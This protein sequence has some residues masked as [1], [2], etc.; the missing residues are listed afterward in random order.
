MTVGESPVATTQGN[1][2]WPVAVALVLF[3]L[4][5]YG[6]AFRLPLSVITLV[7]IVVTY[8]MVIYLFRAIS[9]AVYYGGLWPIAAAGVL[10]LVAGWTVCLTSQRIM[11]VCEMVMMTGTGAVVGARMRAG[12]SG[13]KAYLFGALV[14][15]AGSTAMFGPEWADLMAFVR[16][17]G[18]ESVLTAT[19]N[20]TAFGYHPEAAQAYGVFMA[21]IANVVTRLIPVLMILGVLA[22]YSVAHLWFLA[23][24]I[25]R[26]RSAVL[27]APFTRWR[28]PFE[29]VGLVIL[30]AVGR[31]FGGETIVLIADNLLFGL[32][33]C[34]CVGGV[35]LA[36][37]FLVR[38]NLPLAV[39]VLFYI[40]LVLT[41][42][43]GFGLIVLL[44]FIDSFAD[45]RKLS[46][47]SI[48]LDK[49]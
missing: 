46:A 31:L 4:L 9:G 16:S 36:A 6:V 45:W 29:P 48:E 25:P 39:K 2:V 14:V 43:I 5:K 34:Y 24:G 1:R 32:A 19:Q 3:P 33:V 21:Q 12:D 18:Q 37:H 17:I 30:A 40:A 47:Q 27:L 28:I 26:E 23:R 20:L 11:M 42:L 15:T 35:S 13:A 49:S 44:G 10:A 41:G 7:T 8:V 38:L 22:Q